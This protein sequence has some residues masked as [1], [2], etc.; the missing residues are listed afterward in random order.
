MQVE[1][2]KSSVSLGAD[3]APC[4]SG[5]RL[6]YCAANPGT[7]NAAHAS[8]PDTRVSVTPAIMLGGP[9]DEHSG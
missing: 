5:C 3:R 9:N 6:S 8:A 4:L 7:D 2:G 1:P